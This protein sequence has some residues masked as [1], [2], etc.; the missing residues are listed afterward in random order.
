MHFAEIYLN[1]YI[2]Q[3]EESNKNNIV[4]EFPNNLK[5]CC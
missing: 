3:E 5:I 4:C 2:G 1:L